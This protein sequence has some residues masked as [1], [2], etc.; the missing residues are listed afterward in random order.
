MFVLAGKGVYI[1]V[2]NIS[3]F[4]ATPAAPEEYVTK[5]TDLSGRT[6]RTF[7]TLSNK[8]N[9]LVD[10]AASTLLTRIQ[11]AENSEKVRANTK[12]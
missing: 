4:C 7:V 12:P 10:V 2:S 8:T 5:A 6:R 3:Y 9:L 1:N 11:A